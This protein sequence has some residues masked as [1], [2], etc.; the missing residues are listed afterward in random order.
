MKFHTTIWHLWGG[1]A[2]DYFLHR[3]AQR[4]PE[5]V[6]HITPLKPPLTSLCKVV[7]SSWGPLLHMILSISLSLPLSLD[8]C[9]YHQCR[10]YPTPNYR[11][12][13]LKKRH[14]TDKFSQHSDVLWSL[15]HCVQYYWSISAINLVTTWQSAQ[16]PRS[17]NMWPLLYDDLLQLSSPEGYCHNSRGCNHFWWKRRPSLEARQPVVLM[18]YCGKSCHLLTFELASSPQNTLPA[19]WTGLSEKKRCSG[20]RNSLPTV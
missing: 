3:P 12:S 19:P 5:G 13:S 16:W 9:L 1:C 2:R 10:N 8:S 7:Q 14:K 6:W 15:A 11:E 18:I 17:L 4:L 20:A